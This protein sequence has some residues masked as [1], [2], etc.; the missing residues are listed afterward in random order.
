MIFY[1]KKLLF[2]EHHNLLVHHKEGDLKGY[3]SS[4]ISDYCCDDMHDAIETEE[5]IVFGDGDDPSKEI[6]VCVTYGVSHGRGGTDYS[7]FPIKFCPFCGKGIEVK[8][9][10]IEY[11]NKEVAT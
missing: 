7:Y 6:V 8:E 9:M 11:A 2:H 10:S 3:K 5:T 4:G 1:Y